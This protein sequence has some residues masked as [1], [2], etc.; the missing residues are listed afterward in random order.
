MIAAL[1]TS[2]EQFVIDILLIVAA[3]TVAI[4]WWKK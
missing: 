2:Q 3:V 4:V 1:L